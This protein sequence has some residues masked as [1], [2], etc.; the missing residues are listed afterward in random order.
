[1]IRHE[2]RIPADLEAEMRTY[3]VEII[4]PVDEEIRRGAFSS[5]IEGFI[6]REIAARKSA[7]EIAKPVVD[8]LAALLRGKP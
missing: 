5:W 3:M 8:I 4:D 2:F 7:M 1:M 6:R